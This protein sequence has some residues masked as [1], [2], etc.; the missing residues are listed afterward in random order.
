MLLCGGGA[1]AVPLCRLLLDLGWH[2][3]VFDHRPAYIEAFDES[4]AAEKIAAPAAA[5]SQR[6]ALAHFPAVVVMSHHLETDTRYLEIVAGFDHWHYVGLL[7][8]SHRRERL[9]DAV[10]APAASLRSVIDGPAGLDIGAKEPAG[11]AL[12]IAAGMHAR[13][14]ERGAL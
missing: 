14:A 7:G 12:A 13:L 10:G 1:D 2:V 6:V 3:T 4:L 8:P 5:L 11:I 9:L